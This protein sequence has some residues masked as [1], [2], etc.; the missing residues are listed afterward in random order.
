MYLKGAMVLFEKKEALFLI[1]W[2]EYEVGEW[3][4]FFAFSVD[5]SWEEEEA[6][7]AYLGAMEE[8]NKRE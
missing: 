7:G 2:V 4:S 8:L 5:A 6:W 3:E 1:S